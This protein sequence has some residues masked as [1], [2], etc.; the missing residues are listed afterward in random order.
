MDGPSKR[1]SSFSSLLEQSR[2]LARQTGEYLIQRNV[3]QIDDTTRS[4]HTTLSHS[5]KDV[6]KNKG[7]YLLA[8][9]GF[10]ADKLSRNLNA[11]NLKLTYEPLELALADTDLEGSLKYARLPLFW[12]LTLD[13]FKR[14]SAKKLD[15]DWEGAKSELLEALG[16]S[17]ALLPRGTSAPSTPMKPGMDFTAAALASPATPLGRA[18]AA[19][20]AQEAVGKMTAYGKV[21]DELN[22]QRRE[23]RSFSTMQAFQ[24]AARTVDD[25]ELRRKEVADCWDLLSRIVGEPEQAT[26]AA[27]ALPEA[28]YERTYR[29]A[30]EALSR[31]FLSGAKQ[32]QRV[33]QLVVDRNAKRA[34]LGGEPGMHSL[35][36]AYARAVALSRP[37]AHSQLEEAGSAWAEIYYALRAGDVGSACQLALSANPPLQ[38]FAGLLQAFSQNGHLSELQQADCRRTLNATRDPF[39]QIIYM[40][41]TRHTPSSLPAPISTT[42]DWIWFHLSLIVQEENGE[43]FAA[44]L[45]RLQQ[46][47]CKFGPDHFNAKKHPLLYFQVVLITLQ[48]EKAIEF[49]WGKGDYAVEAV[50]FATGLYYYGVLRVPDADAPRSPNSIYSETSGRSAVDLPRMLWHYALAVVEQRRDLALALNYIHLVR[51]VALEDLMLKDFVLNTREV[52]ALLGT[53]GREGLVLRVLGDAARVRRLREVVA[54]ACE[55]RAE[56]PAAVK[57]YHEA[58]DY[59]KVL[60]LLNAALGPLVSA[61]GPDR[62]AL[63]ALALDVNTRYSTIREAPTRSLETLRTLIQTAHFF[64]LSNANRLPEALQR[65]EVIGILPFDQATVPEKVELFAKLDETVKRCVGDLI[66]AAMSVLYKLYG[67]IAPGTGSQSASFLFPSDPAR[68]H[69]MEAIKSRARALAAFTGRIQYRLPSDVTSRLLRFEVLMS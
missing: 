3:D 26:S 30:P 39:K 16:F 52:D 53:E 57:L 34:E 28:V 58:G 35:A 5:T 42:Q 6:A 38:E 51:D 29:E 17:S 36:R 24:Q 20:S 37:G 19:R 11:V 14:N 18:G 54:A 68:L 22:Q 10:D 55:E 12:T 21:V 60:S 1:A 31:K 67:A 8:T 41:L 40:L 59:E 62:Q 43:A 44:S 33:M 4:L 63:I 48:F 15:S 9:K 61:A 50:H 66:L 45:R 7:R 49:L 64:D 13:H 46:Q 56:L 65:L 23:K 32:Y 69:E 25:T 47:V 2:Q 27:V